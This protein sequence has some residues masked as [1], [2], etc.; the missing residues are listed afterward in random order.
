MLI[1]ALGI[2]FIGF[3]AKSMPVSWPGKPALPPHLLKSYLCLS[4]QH[5]EK[6]TKI[7][8]KSVC[9]SAAASDGPQCDTYETHAPACRG[10]AAMLPGLSRAVQFSRGAHPI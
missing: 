8:T 2:N 10:A 7:P 3:P 6:P 1:E 9:L 5:G 4:S